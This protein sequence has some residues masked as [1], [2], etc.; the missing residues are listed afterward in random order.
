MT[1][2]KAPHAKVSASASLTLSSLDGIQRNVAQTSGG[3][4]GGGY[5]SSG[6]FGGSFSGTYGPEGSLASASIGPGGVQQT[7][8]VYPE[9]PAVPNV[10]TR[11]A[12]AG[13]PRGGSY[14]VFTSSQSA[15]S[16]LNGKPM[17][18][19]RATTTVNDNGKVTTYTVQNP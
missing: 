9:N 7:A 10:N 8:A 15:T 13:G 1:S 18:F 6:G 11:F 14:G 12:A 5:D 16:N 3:G 2:S 19:H 4:F 17:S